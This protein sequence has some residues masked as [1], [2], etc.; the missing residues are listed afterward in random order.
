MGG[1][2]PAVNSGLGPL[3]MGFLVVVIQMLAA[4]E[5]PAPSP[6]PSPTPQPLTM[7]RLTGA[8]R[9]STPTL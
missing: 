4:Q 7:G 6:A 8:S 3:E 1:G 9:N 5:G 2:S